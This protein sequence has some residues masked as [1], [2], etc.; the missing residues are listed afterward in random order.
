MTS[1]LLL[2]LFIKLLYGDEFFD[3]L[4]FFKATHGI[5]N[6]DNDVLPVQRDGNRCYKI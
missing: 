6:L 4:F 2:P 3:Q 5:I 1:P